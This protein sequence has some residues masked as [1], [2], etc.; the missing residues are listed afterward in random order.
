MNPI[1]QWGVVAQKEGH[2]FLKT[3]S[4]EHSHFYCDVENTRF[5]KTRYNATIEN[6]GGSALS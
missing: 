2:Y 3:T 4:P 5:L 6:P 1:P